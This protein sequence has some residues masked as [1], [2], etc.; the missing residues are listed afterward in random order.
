MAAPL[1]ISAGMGLLTGGSQILGGFAQADKE[2]KAGMNAARQTAASD[3]IRQLATNRKNQGKL[4]L[5]NY[6]LGRYRRDKKEIFDSVNAAGM[7]EQRRLNSVMDSFSFS[8]VERLRNLYEVQGSNIAAMESG[9]GNRTGERAAAMGTSGTFGYE[10]VQR[11]QMQREAA[12]QSDM[13]REDI[14]RQG[15]MQA[16]QS[17]GDLDAPMQFDMFFNTPLSMPRRQSGLSIASN[18]IGGLTSGAQAGMSMY[19]FGQKNFGWG[20]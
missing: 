1:L 17:Y 3:A 18:F 2:Y 16:S 5:L 11:A 19:S 14:G 20:D 8:Q 6:G 9:G 15:Y 10:S 13:R 7:A 4:D 12:L